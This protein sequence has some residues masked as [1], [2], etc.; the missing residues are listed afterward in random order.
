VDASQPPP[1]TNAL[2]MAMAALDLAIERH[3]AARDI[4]DLLQGFSSA[5]ECVWWICTIDEH[6]TDRSSDYKSARN[7]DDFGCCIPGLRWI[8][9]RL[10]HQLPLTVDLDEGTLFGGPGV[11]YFNKTFMWRLAADIP[12]PRNL[13]HNG[14]REIYVEYVEGEESL[15]PIARAAHWLKRQVVTA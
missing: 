3:T 6:L 8:R 2:T 10:T 7:A 5:G 9:N 1:S 11:F 15:V 14:G 13:K 12:P 4:R